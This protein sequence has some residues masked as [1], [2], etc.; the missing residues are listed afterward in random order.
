MKKTTLISATI[1]AAVGIATLASAQ[2]PPI[3]RPPI[4]RLPAQATPVL[5]E[6]VAAIR[7][8]DRARVDRLGLVG[9]AP[10]VIAFERRNEQG[11]AIP[12]PYNAC[13]PFGA[14]AFKYLA[15]DDRN[16]LDGRH[17]G[18][19]GDPARLGDGFENLRAELARQNLTVADLRIEFGDFALTTDQFPLAA[20][21]AHPKRTESRTYRGAAWRIR[22][23]DPNHPNSFPVLVD[24]RTSDLTLNVSYNDPSR[25]DD[26]EIGGTVTADTPTLYVSDHAGA[27]SLGR[28]ILRDLASRRVHLRFDSFQPAMRNT[29]ANAVETFSHRDITV[30]ARF[31]AGTA[32]L[33]AIVP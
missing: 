4:Q 15:T 30:G 24:G 25:C 27:T 10:T 32:V 31:T 26:D 11:Y 16:N 1:G 20:V 13:A 6:N 17:R 22:M 7:A 9:V 2:V 8:A 28:A 33:S 23:R 18:I 14:R 5:G 19:G 12:A 29:D 21:N 3:Q